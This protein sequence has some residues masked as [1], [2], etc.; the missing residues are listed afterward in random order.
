MHEILT[1]IVSNVLKFATTFFLYV[2]CACVVGLIAPSRL[3]TIAFSQKY[4]AKDSEG[5]KLN[6]KDELP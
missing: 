2:R 4:P 3:N 5:K 6:V 1:W